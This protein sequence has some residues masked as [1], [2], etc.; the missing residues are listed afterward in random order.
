MQGSPVQ[1]DIPGRI[2]RLV[3]KMDGH[4]VVVRGGGVVVSYG[5]ETD[6][7]SVFTQI[8]SSPAIAQLRLA[9]KLKECLHLEDRIAYIRL[10]YDPQKISAAQFAQEILVFTQLVARLTCPHP[11]HLCDMWSCKKKTQE[12]NTLVLINDIPHLLCDDCVKALPQLGESI[13]RD[14][15]TRPEHFWR[16][17]AAALGG[18]VAYGLVWAV[19]WMLL[20]LLRIDA[21]GTIFFMGAFLATVWVMDKVG[22]KSTLKGLFV[23][24]PFSVL[25]VVIGVY[26]HLALSSLVS[27]KG[28]IDAI[29]SSWA[30]SQQDSQQARFLIIFDVV[31]AL[32]GILDYVMEKRGWMRKLANLPVE[33]I[34]DVNTLNDMAG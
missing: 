32:L 19:V 15:D 8:K 25:S 27:G 7:K 3:G 14:I 12:S 2:Q 33:V 23:A 6:I 28:L 13:K 4:Y 5:P 31:L 24:L 21:L 29:T 1:G 34:G 10:K 26:G 20:S 17:T 9:G 30:L 16:G 11:T 18:S 22:A